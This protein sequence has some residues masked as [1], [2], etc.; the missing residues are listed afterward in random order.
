MTAILEKELEKNLTYQAFRAMD[1]PDDDHFN[2][3]LI[4]GEIVRKSSPSILHQRISGNIYFQIRLFLAQN[5]IGEVFA[6]PL[7]VVLEDI[8]SPVAVVATL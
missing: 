1:F 8:T 5:P 7:D 2:Y 3:E 6:A 4:N